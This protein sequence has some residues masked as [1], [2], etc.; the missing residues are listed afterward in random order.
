MIKY[1]NRHGDIDEIARIPTINIFNNLT[2]KVPRFGFIIPTFKRADLLPYAIDSI[3][4]QE[5]NEP[6]EILVVD[7]NPERDDS[8]EQLMTSRYNIPGITYYKNTINHRQENNWNKLFA[9][10]R[11]EW[12]IM[13]HDDDM[14]F[15]DY[16]KY[17]IE[18]MKYYPNNIGGFFPS[19]IGGEF[20]D[21]QLPERQKSPIHARIIKEVDFLQGCILGAPLGMCVRRDIVNMI[22]GVNKHSGVAV[23]YDFYNRF[24][25][26]T[27]V[28][29]MY[30]YPLGAWRIMDNV[31]Q[32]VST[33]LF[34]IDWGDILKMD[35]LE[36]CGLDW[37]APLFKY[38][39]KGFDEQHIRN[40]YREMGKEIDVSTLRPCSSFD[41]IVY[42]VFRFFFAI[43][44]RMRKG[45]QKIDVAG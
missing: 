7:D 18:C 15:P 16:M 4:G 10:A 14:L 13:L 44:R 33:V 39:L 12:M 24:I 42:K 30:S 9:L 34:C 29:K 43:K 17:L 35:T 5:T 27:N 37:L 45:S 8:T 31:S 40:W 22:G 1:L 36:D 23:D 3:L 21:G 32:K 41:K 38:Y 26:Y 2:E 19:F 28:V 20:T 11:T 25:K 6:F